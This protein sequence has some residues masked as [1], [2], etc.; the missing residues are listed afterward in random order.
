M[1][2]I[3]LH[4]NDDIAYTCINNT[5]IDEY[6]PYANG[7]YVKVYLL[8]MRKLSD[9]CKDIS[10]SNMAD[11]L[12]LTEK[13]ILRALKYWEKCGLLKICKDSSGT[14]RDI[15]VTRP[16]AKSVSDN[17]NVIIEPVRK[18]IKKD[19]YSRTYTMSEIAEVAAEPDFSWTINIIEK[20]ME[21]PLSPS[22][23]ELVVFLYDNL[24]FSPELILYLYEYCISHGKKSSKYIQAVAINWAKD[25][26]D[27]VEKA[28]QYSTRFESDYMSVMKAFGLSQAPAPAQKDYIDSWLSMG[29]GNDVILEACN[30]TILAINEPSFKYANGILEK[31]HKAGIHT[32]N[33]IKEADLAHA[34]KDKKEPRK[35]VT[36]S[37]KNSFNSYTQRNYSKTDYTTLE[38]LLN[39]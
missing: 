26:V 9:N 16:A 17:I 8:I 6:M 2:N 37:K 29:F 24:R 28:M 15:T 7:S 13:D 11:S 14:I 10:I 34:S 5:F 18:T 20:Y 22:D 33:E 36:S 3:V 1:N 25:S 21:Q 12:E 35:N 38:Q 27:T 32:L 31:W 4:N 39:K 19:K 23:V 30:R